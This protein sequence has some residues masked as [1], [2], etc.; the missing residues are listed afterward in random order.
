MQQAQLQEMHEDWRKRDNNCPSCRAD[1][2]PTKPS[3]VVVNMLKNIL[4][5]CENCLELF[6]YSDYSSHQIECKGKTAFTCSLC[7]KSGMTFEDMRTHWQHFCK[8][9][10][11][12]CN[13][14]NV[15]F[16][17]DAISSHYICNEQV[18][19]EKA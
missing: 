14:C 9:I 10:D 3:R 6:K 1:S 12:N 7:S 11:L 13:T 17:R 18:M 4:F 19:K 5:K 8:Q 15:I 2:A 16:K